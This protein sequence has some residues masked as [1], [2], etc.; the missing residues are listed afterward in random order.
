MK[1]KS[2]LD[3][4][5][6]DNLARR[7]RVWMF[8]HRLRDFARRRVLGYGFVQRWR[9]RRLPRVA[10]SRRLA[11]ALRKVDG[12]TEFPALYL[13]SED[14]LLTH[15]KDDAVSTWLQCPL[16]CRGVTLVLA[17][18]AKLPHQGRDE[19]D[20]VVRRCADRWWKAL[21]ADD[22]LAGAYPE[23]EIIA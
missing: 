22:E 11:E 20:R 6:G 23:P 3:P 14:V 12:A 16:R 9:A 7:L 1:T 4:G 5:Y 8:M 21:K 18:S 2:M 17:V 10:F 13:G 19:Q 15:F